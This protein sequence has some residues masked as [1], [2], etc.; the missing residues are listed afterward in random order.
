VATEVRHQA[1]LRDGAAGNVK[2]NSEVFTSAESFHYFLTEL[3]L[4]VASGSIA[5]SVTSLTAARRRLAKLTITLGQ[6]G[7]RS[8]NKASS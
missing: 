3:E 2:Q 5:W 1:R 4:L 7:R 8:Q 6:I